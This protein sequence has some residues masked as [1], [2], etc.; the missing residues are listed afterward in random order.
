[1]AADF[2][3]Y[4][5]AVTYRHVIIYGGSKAA[6]VSKQVDMNDYNAVKA[7]YKLPN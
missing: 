6:R 1:M 2:R 3:T 4:A 7:F 5:K